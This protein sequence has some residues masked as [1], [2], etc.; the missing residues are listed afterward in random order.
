MAELTPEQQATEKK[1]RASAWKD[2]L[3][4]KRWCAWF[5][6]DPKPDGDGFAKVPV[7][8]HSS[9]DGWNTFDE[10]CAK[11]KP[12]QGFGFNF[13]GGD[14]HPLD[15]DHV[16][17]NNNGNIC[18]EA[19]L[20]LSRLQT[21][22]EISI[23]GRGL[24]VLFRGSVR[25]HQL[26][27]T[28]VQYWHPAKAPR[29]F[30]VTGDVI[31]QA[32]STIRDVG[33]EFNYVFSTAAHISA[34][35]REELATI[36]PDQ[37]VKLPAEPVKKAT[38]E[39]AKPTEKKRQRHADFNM[40]EFLEWA[41][42]SVDNTTN[43]EIGKCYRVTS[44]PIKGEPH[45]GQNGTT[46]NFGLT[47]DGGLMFHCQ[48]TGCVEYHFSDV[49][50]MLEEKHGKY[51]GKLWKEEQILPFLAQSDS[52]NAETLV[53]RH[54]DN[55]RFVHDEQKW[56]I[57]NGVNWAIDPDGEIHRL[58][59]R[60][61]TANHKE[62]VD[63]TASDTRTKALKYLASCANRNKLENM[64]ARAQIL[65]PVATTQQEFD[66]HPMLLNVSNGTIDLS[67]QTFRPHS[68]E[69]MLIM[70]ADVEYLEGAKCPQFQRFLT[71]IFQDKAVKEREELIAFLQRAIGYSLT[72]D[73]REQVC[74]LLQGDGKNGKGVLLKI[75][76]KLLGAYG[77]TIP[78]DMLVTK[79]NDSSGPRDGMVQLFGKRFASA[80]E[81]EEGKRLHESKLKMMVAPDG[82]LR[83]SRLYE[84]SF[85]FDNT[86]KLWMSTNYEPKISGTDEGI[87]RRIRRINCTHAI[88]EK[89][90]VL[91]LD[92]K[93]WAAESSGILNWALEGVRQWLAGGLQPPQ[94]VIKATETYRLEQN[95]FARFMVECLEFDTERKVPAT[96]LYNTYKEWAKFSREYAHTQTKFGREVAKLF[97][98]KGVVDGRSNE[99]RLEYRGVGISPNAHQFKEY[100]PRFDSD[101]P[102]REGYSA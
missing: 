43:N 76:S 85:E 39:R 72:A 44:C 96:G 4:E 34:K 81:G 36:D 77:T 15:L 14:L 13:F 10:L 99:G 60:T 66:Q 27:E 97:A 6:G 23:S 74:F 32:F 95:V 88:P 37:Y 73:T 51:P 61:I 3:N 33:E 63:W 35:C 80:S 68:R 47:A 59:L 65:R 98:K 50:R 78:F 11:L 25:G 31:G 49:L 102:S 58:A 69:D 54:G 94:H 18:P 17:N 5:K 26:G 29:F 75:I 67:T 30:T 52:G 82:R 84:D 41:G 22:S 8:S 12:G 79:P 20:L 53:K 71:D 57:W 101:T 24:H 42:L 38:R 7:G 91:D 55:I 45:V 21:F 86:F 16:R 48:S 19:M 46:T 92:V 40:E 83:G 1:I 89:D 64:V 100:Q 9:P 70:V 87:W 90:R 2:Y 28:C 62:V 93:L 56:R